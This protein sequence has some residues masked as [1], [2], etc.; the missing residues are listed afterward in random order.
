M[1][2]H[3]ASPDP[4]AAA[5]FLILAM[6]AAGI[7]QVLWLRSPL[8]ARFS[9]PVDLGLTL[10]G[11]RLFGD[12]K[13]LRGFMVLPAA[14]ALS[15]ALLGSVRE[16]L[17]GWLALGMWTLEPGHYAGL[18]FVAGLAFMLAELPNSFLKRQMDIDPGGQPRGPWLRAVFFAADRVDSLLGMLIAV[19]LLVPLPAATWMWMLLVA[20]AVHA[21]FS[22][23]LYASGVKARAL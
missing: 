2:A 8:A 12:N 15:F 18:G 11:R 9:Q 3:L 20:P 7:A 13:R 22:S 23:L 6:S 1:S 5:A 19:S 10:R 14:A 16:A 4:A 17:P 21:L